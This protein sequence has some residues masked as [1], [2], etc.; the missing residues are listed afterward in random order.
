MKKSNVIFVITV[1]IFLAFL[2][3]TKKSYLDMQNNESERLSSVKWYVNDENDIK[4]IGNLAAEFKNDGTFNFYYTDS[5]VSCMSGKY[6][7]TFKGLVKLKCDKTGF[8]PP[9]KWKCKQKA[10][11]KY[12]INENKLTLTYKGVSC[13]FG[14]K[15]VDKDEK[16][17]K[18]NSDELHNMYFINKQAKMLVSFYSENMYIYI[19]KDTLKIFGENK[20]VLGETCLFGT[21]N[22]DASKSKITVLTENAG[23]VKTNPMWPEMGELGEYEFLYRIED[24]YKKIVLQYNDKAYEFTRVINE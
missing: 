22:Q 5:S 20:E 3:I 8:N 2:I 11:F 21:Y 24:N 9:E 23:D 1:V 12:K 7:I 18:N 4:N 14:V 15:G 17:K 10:S 16:D 6:T 19:L 13:T